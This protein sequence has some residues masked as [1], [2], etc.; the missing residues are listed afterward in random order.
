MKRMNF[1]IGMAGIS[2]ALG[3]MVIGCDQDGDSGGNGG[4]GSYTFEFKVESSSYFDGDYKVTKVEFINGSSRDDPVLETKIVNIAPG[5]MTSAYR[6]SGFTQKNDDDVHIF[7]VKVTYNNDDEDY[8]FNWTSAKNND[9][10]L[11]YCGFGD[12]SFSDGNW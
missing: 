1:L 3:M 6:V 4:G 7:G 11:V 2:L 8:D 10:I 12:L 5:D 9:K